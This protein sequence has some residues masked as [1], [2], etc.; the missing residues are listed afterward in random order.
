TASLEQLQLR[1]G[2]IRC[3]NCAHIFDGFEAVVS[4]GADAARSAKEPSVRHDMPAPQEPPAHRE[5][6]VPMPSVLR[7]RPG[8][9]GPEHHITSR[10]PGRD[11][12]FIISTSES[13]RAQESRQD[14]TFGLNPHT[15]R[16]K[17][18]PTVGMP[19]AE[20]VQ[21]VVHDASSDSGPR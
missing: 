20:V 2:Y 6:S 17:P 1:K 16:A 9:N 7:Q 18:E 19:R 12:A 4:P 14:H 5:P 13:T 15:I 10:A 21:P 3:I 8:G 11:T